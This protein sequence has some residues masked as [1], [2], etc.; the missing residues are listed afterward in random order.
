MTDSQRAA[1]E[2]TSQDVCVVAGPG[3][4]KTRV[5][6]ERFAWLVDQRKV[7]PSRI[8]AITF[9]EKAA[10]EIKERLAARLGSSIERAWVLTIDGFCTRLL[11]ENAIAA[12]LAPDFTVLEESAA[13]RLQRES[14]DAALEKI[15]RERPQVTRRL[16]ESLD[17]STQEDGRN[18][19]LARA[20][21]DIHEAMRV[22]GIDHLPPPV[23]NDVHP[24]AEDRVRDVLA[25]RFASGASVPKLREWAQC[26]LSLPDKISRDHFVLLE[27]LSEIHLNRLGRNSPATAA[28]REL[29]NELAPLLE[30]QWIAEWYSNLLDLLREAIK[31][32]AEQYRERKRRDALLD[33]ADLEEHAIRLLESDERVRSQTKERFD[34]IL[35][36]ELQD[37]NPLQW[38]LIGLIRSHFFAVGDIN[39]SIYG[40]RHAEPAVFEQYRDGLLQNGFAT[41]E[42][43]ENHRSTDQILDAVTRVLDGAAG[44]EYRPLIGKRGAGAPV[45]RMVASGDDANQGEASLIAA[46]ICELKAEGV[47]FH[48]IAILVRTMTAAHLIERALDRAGIP[49]VVSGG[50]TFFE[51]REIR[52]LM[53]LLGALANPL[54]E[55]ALVGVLRSPLVG[56]SDEEI[57][58]IGREGWLAE[59]Q[60]YFGELRSRAG[61]T[62]PDLLLARALD[63][64]GYTA[65]VPERAQSN[66]DKFLGVLRD[67]RHLTFA[68]VLEE[69]EARRASQAE[70]D[71]PPAEAGDLVRLMSMHAAKGLEFPVVFVSALHRG[72]DWRK[73]VI[74]FSAASGLG[75]KWRHPATGKGAS[76][77]AHARIVEELKRKERAEE[78]RLLYVAMTRAEDLLILS[79]AERARGAWL[80]LVAKIPVTRAA[81]RIVE[82]RVT[83]AA[84][85]ARASTRFADPPKITSQFDSSVAATAIAAF[86]V[87]PRQFLLSS[88]DTRPGKQSTG[89]LELGIEVHRVLAGEA[90]S[91]EALALA[92]RFHASEIGRRAARATRLEREFDF[93]LPIEDVIVRGQI[94]LWFEEA[95]ELIL[96]DYKTDRDESSSDVYALQLSLYAL[97]IEKYVGRAPDRAVLC[98]LR[99][100]QTVDAKTDREQARD[101]VRTFRDAQEDLKYPIRP[102][103]R[104]PRCI[105]YQN[106]C[107]AQLTMTDGF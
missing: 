12:G 22:A 28:A 43:R 65:K 15:F 36:D 56:L 47:D 4:G 100:G 79:H 35:M 61:F 89:A 60:K 90:G 31:R 57:S 97:A 69:M 106:R 16:L 38:K 107:P 85:I 3:S 81:D 82:A 98:Y 102:G 80:D 11:R 70:A 29:K 71:A 104:C 64:C 93:L 76:D 20:L 103:S 52:D 83:A 94:D 49:F 14:A 53:A 41:D 24:R 74:A 72:P 8:L 13:Q 73:P 75:A 87:C 5:L 44:I 19:D 9:T 67:H 37:T 55:I 7:D 30:Q 99:T 68:G 84:P 27:A 45:E 78:N 105:F 62:P 91:P 18:P 63:E 54:D 21:L 2:R 39:Q 17:L 59:F 32:I 34:E 95:G 92:E 58:Q 25:D 48:K 1:V 50:R 51:S 46:R 40:F 77:T 86:A 88:I 101:A 6:V 42:L 26:F 33:F 96:A 10:A 23:L 66:I